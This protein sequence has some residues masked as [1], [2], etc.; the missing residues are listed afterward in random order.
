MSEQRSIAAAFEALLPD[1]AEEEIPMLLAIL[2][3]IAGDKYRGLGW[4]DLRYSGT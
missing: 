3:R 4:R 2:E 1:M